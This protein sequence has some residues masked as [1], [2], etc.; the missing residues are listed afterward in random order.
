MPDTR[1]IK[2]LQLVHEDGGA[3]AATAIT[4]SHKA[5]PLFAFYPDW[6]SF[7]ERDFVG[8]SVSWARDNFIRQMRQARLPIA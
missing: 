5:I 1:V 2:E 4:T 6:V 3:I 7:C 8:R